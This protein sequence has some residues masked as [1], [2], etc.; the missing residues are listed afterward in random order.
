QQEEKEA[1]TSEE[2]ARADA[3]KRS[4][5]WSY[6]AIGLF[7]IVVLLT[8][9]YVTRMCWLA[10]FFAMKLKRKPNAKNYQNAYHHLLKVLQNKGMEKKPD[11]TLR[12]YAKQID[13][14]YGTNEMG[15]LTNYYER[16]L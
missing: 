11:Q 12:E 5:P 1:E 4:V 2:D 6:L 15:E 7:I 13:A 9:M 3:E 10:A 14:R 16:M 8:V